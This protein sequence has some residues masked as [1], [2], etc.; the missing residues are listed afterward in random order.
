MNHQLSHPRSSAPSG[1]EP[2]SSRATGFA[3]GAL[4]RPFQRLFS[5]GAS[6]TVAF[7]A[8]AL[9]AACGGGSSDSVGSTGGDLSPRMA[10]IAGTVEVAKSVEMKVLVI[11][12]DGTRTELPGRSLRSLT[13][14]ACPTTRWCSRAPTRPRCRW[15]RARCPTAPAT[16]STRASF[17]RLATLPYLEPSCPAPYPAGL[18]CERLRKWEMLRQYQFDFGVRSATMYTSGR[19]DRPTP[20]GVQL[21]D[22]TYGLTNCR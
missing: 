9:L 8:A 5:R 22:L 11:S 7:V 3:P 13:R 15:W 18:L 12:A 19:T 14:S 4:T 16:A 6:L 2:S 20:N 1:T 21:L 17:S 10:Q